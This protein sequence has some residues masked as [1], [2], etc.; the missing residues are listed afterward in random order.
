MLKSQTEPQIVTI[1]AEHV[2]DEVD[3]LPVPDASTT[4][5][6]AI[7][8]SSLFQI[9]VVSGLAFCGPAMADAISGLGGGGQASPYFVSESPR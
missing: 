4:K 2:T 5:L 3:V 1:E 6:G 7:Y 9:C 8:R